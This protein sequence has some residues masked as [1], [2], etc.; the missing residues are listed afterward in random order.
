[1]EANCTNLTE[2]ILR[3]TLEIIYLLTGEDNIVVKKTSG[4]GQNSVVVPLHSL[5]VPERNNEQKI[6]EVT[7]KITDLLMGETE[8]WSNFNVIIK[9]E[10]ED[11]EEED[12]VMKERE[13]LEGHKDLYKDVMMED[14]PPLTSPGGSSNRNPPERC[15]QPLYSRDSTQEDHTIPHHH[16]G[17]G[18]FA[19]KTEVKAEEETYMRG[20]QLSTKETEMMV[21]ATKE[22]TSLDA[23][24]GGNNGWKAQEGYLISSAD[25]NKDI[26]QYSPGVSIVTQNIH[27]KPNY[28]VTSTDLF[29]SED[30]NDESHT[31]IPNVQPSFQRPNTL[32]D[33]SNPEESSP[34]NFQ[35][36]QVF[37]QSFTTQ[38]DLVV[39]ESNNTVEKPFACSECEKSFMKKSHLVQHRRI[40]TG[41]KP[42]MCSE[43]NEQKILEVTKTIIDLLMEENE[44][45]KNVCISI[46]EESKEEDDEYGVIKEPSEGHKDLCKDIMMENQP[47]LTSPDGSSNENPP[48]RCHRPLYFQDSTQE[49]HTIPHHHQSN[50]N[51][52]I[53]KEIKKEEEESLMEEWAYLEGHKDFYKDIMMEDQ[54]FLTS[55]DGSS[56]GNPPERCPRPLYSRDSIQEDHT[57]PHHHQRE[58]VIDMKIEVKEEEEIKGNRD[59]HMR[60]HT[61]EKPFSCPECGSCFAQKVTLILHQRTHTAQGDCL[62]QHAE[63]HENKAS[64]S[65]SECGKSF[66]KKSEQHVHHRGPTSKETFPCP[67]CKKSFKR[68]CRQEWR[69][70]LTNKVMAVQKTEV[71]GTELGAMEAKCTNLTERILRLTLEIYLLTGEVRR[72]ILL[73]DYHANVP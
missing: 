55:P 46:K 24:T 49:V 12:S 25:Y 70:N 42:Y 48:E 41:E 1:M 31:I 44:K 21:T 7:Q 8:N 11:G 26:A 47:P 19:I 50:F 65:C 10:I 16:Q 68:K 37:E 43:N 73:S 2:R 14:Q 33:P 30:P 69:R 22:E 29:N 35:Q 64:P 63:P 6:L 32:S 71:N 18:V 28:M 57:I 60:M 17:I 53:K 20:N 4:D 23:S 58:E 40:H 13:Y 59:N 51:I 45:W 34:N 56:N 66:E 61:G 52:T 39:P 62:D 67:D 9:E 15:P 38:P 3:L 36:F 54:L 72:S 27:H 5:L